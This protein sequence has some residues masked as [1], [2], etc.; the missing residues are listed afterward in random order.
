[1]VDK[2]NAFVETDD[3]GVEKLETAV[4][5]ETFGTMLGDKTSAVDE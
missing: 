2:S 3:T 1:M 4:E 5:C